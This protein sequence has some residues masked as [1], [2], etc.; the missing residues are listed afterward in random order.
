MYDFDKIVDRTGTG[1]VKWE[2]QHMFGVPKGLLPFWIADTDFE[3]LPEIIEAINSRCAHPMLGY[4]VPG[5]ECLEAVRGW[6]ERRHGWAIDTSWIVPSAGVMTAIGFAIRA[7]TDVGDRVLIFSPVYDPFF[8]VVK[9]T[10][11]TLV[12]LHLTGTGDS[13]EIDFGKLERELADGVRA[14]ILC[15]PH[16][17]VGRIWSVE[18]LG[19]IAG[20]CRKYG[21]HILSDDVHGDIELFGNVYTPMGS[22]PEARDLTVTFTS[23]S[24]TFHMAGLG[25]SALIIPNRELRRPVAG[26]LRDGF[27]FSANALALAAM[28]AAYTHGDVY[29]D[30]LNAYLSANAA[31]AGDYFSE[32][33][34]EV[35]VTKM[36][37]TFL[38]WLDFSCLGLT[39]GQLSDIMAKE[40][41]IALS[42][43][44][45]YGKQAEGFM[46]LNIGCPRSMLEKGLSAIREL[47]DNE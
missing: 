40:Y 33:M 17:P 45:L 8:N 1:S 44:T 31:F 23:I 36:E 15:N 29:V 38:M 26:A 16:N 11:R 2:A 25:S 7:L 28:E 27:I 34:P 32:N 46:R 21:V 10:D 42:P 19:K 24:K 30:E 5:K 35:G 39:C 13:Y 4:T 41:N 9:N 37:G 6:Q 43:G 47:Y 3:T 22:L 14:M 12:D 18:E 20:L